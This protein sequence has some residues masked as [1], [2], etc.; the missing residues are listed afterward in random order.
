MDT[1]TTEIY[2]YL[3][4]LSLPDA[5]PICSWN[6]PQTGQGSHPSAPATDRAIAPVRHNRGHPAPP[7]TAARG[8][9]PAPNAPSASRAH[10][11]RSEEHTSELQSLMT[12]SYDVLCLKK[13]TNK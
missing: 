1:A 11:G 9:A 7:E 6:R 10:R 8:C 4:T 5:L 13:K 12:I 3:H 2:T